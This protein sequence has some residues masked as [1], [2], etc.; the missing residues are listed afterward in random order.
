MQTLKQHNSGKKNVP[1]SKFWLIRLA[2]VTDPLPAQALSLLA[3]LAAGA[4]PW[5]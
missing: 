5:L 2:R 4:Q 1:G 3:E